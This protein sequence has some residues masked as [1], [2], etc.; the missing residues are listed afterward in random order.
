MPATGAPNLLSLRDDLA[1]SVPIEVHPV[2]FN[3]GV[4]G[5]QAC[6]RQF[7]DPTP[8]VR[9]PSSRQMSWLSRGLYDALVDFI[10]RAEDETNALRPRKARRLKA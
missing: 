5:S 7:E 6:R 3:R 10:S 4:A 1:V 9:E 2:F 8:D